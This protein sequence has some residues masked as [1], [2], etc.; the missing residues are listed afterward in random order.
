[1]Y[2][3]LFPVLL[4]VLI[5]SCQENSLENTI[6]EIPVPITTSIVQIPVAQVKPSTNPKPKVSASPV[7]VKSPTPL[8]SQSIKPSAV[9][10]K[11][12]E[13]DDNEVINTE[14]EVVKTN[15]NWKEFNPV[16]KGKKY[17]YVYSIISGNSSV[18]ADITREITD[19]E[20]DSYKVIQ[21]VINSGSDTQLKPTEITILLNKDNSPSIIPVISVN[22]SKVET[23]VQFEVS[24]K[25]EK[26]KVPFKEFDAFKVVSKSGEITTTNWYGKDA[27]LIKAVQSSKT[28]TF[29]LELKDL[30]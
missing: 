22:G 27:G 20:D 15:V 19:V 6:A 21:T 30:K 23:N 14:T 7:S 12:Q 3:R 9:S 2:N 17:T 8:P 25:T 29:T 16:I 10:D 18:K 1:M 4:F 5:I 24:E 28:S 13:P 11:I 26:I